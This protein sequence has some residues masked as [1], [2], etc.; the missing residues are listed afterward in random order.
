MRAESERL[1]DGTPLHL[2]KGN[3]S[4]SYRFLLSEAGDDLVRAFALVAAQRDGASRSAAMTAEHLAA[5]QS[6][7]AEMGRA[8]P[9]PCALLAP[10]AG[11]DDTT[12]SLVLVTAEDC[13]LFPATADGW[14]ALFP[15]G[16]TAADQRRRHGLAR[17]IW[18]RLPEPVRDVLSPDSPHSHDILISGDRV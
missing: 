14:N 6:T 10:T 11:A 13:R 15:V 12:L 7:L 4:A 3:A 2:S 17:D 9:R 18:R 16:K 8:G 5:A 1:A